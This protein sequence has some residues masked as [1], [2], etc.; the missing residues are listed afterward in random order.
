MMQNNFLDEIFKAIEEDPT[1]EFE[2]DLEKQRFT[3]LASGASTQ[4]EI[5]EYKKENLLNG[6]DDIDYLLNMKKD[7]E[8]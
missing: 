3:I 4:F 6:F 7:I 8:E 2:I 1:T 5:N